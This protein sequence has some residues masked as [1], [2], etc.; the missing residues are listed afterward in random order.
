MLATSLGRVKQFIQIL[1]LALI[2]LNQSA[3]PVF[4]HFLSVLAAHLAGKL[5][6]PADI[7]RT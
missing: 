4:C 6:H 7:M 3:A 5:A 2:V 1:E